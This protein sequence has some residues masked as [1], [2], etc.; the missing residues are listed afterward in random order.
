MSKKLV[1]QL[2]ED[3]T[4]VSMNA[5]PLPV[6]NATMFETL[7]MEWGNRQ[8]CELSVLLVMARA[9]TML[10][11]THHWQSRGDSYYGDHLL[12]DR[13]YTETLADIDTIAERV[14]G[15]AGVELVNSSLQASQVCKL[16]CDVFGASIGIPRSTELMQRSLDAEEMYGKF[17]ET[18]KECLKINNEL[19]YGTDNLLAGIADKCE[20]RIYLLKQRLSI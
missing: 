10:H 13:L 20:G 16:V 3:V 15:L 2:S 11:Q 9:I 14:V 1:K 6:Q 4:I 5:L 19:S 18:C 17:V 8:F 12:F 7:R